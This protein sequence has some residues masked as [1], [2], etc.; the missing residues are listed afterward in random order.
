MELL[1]PVIFVAM[2]VVMLFIQV[3]I[4][5]KKEKLKEYR[6][7]NEQFILPFLND[8]LLF[9]ENEADY[10]R[11]NGIDVKINP[12]KVIKNIQSK[13]RYSNA[14]IMSALYRYRNVS[15]YFEGKGEARSL[16]I[17]EVFFFYLECALENFQKSKYDD[18]VLLNT[19]STNQK[20]YGMAL[21]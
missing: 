17:Y 19:I 10:L 2:I 4:I 7:V 9:I 21:F 13:S 5:M 8:V 6:T 1:I 3:M 14:K 18:E 16:T 12:H 11:G 15:S 20:I